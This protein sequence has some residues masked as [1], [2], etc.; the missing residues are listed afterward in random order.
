[1]KDLILGIGESFLNIT[2]FIV[3]IAVVIIGLGAIFN[4]GFFYG[5]SIIVIGIIVITV[6]TYFIYLLIDI[7]DKSAK[8][9]ELLSKILEDK[10]KEL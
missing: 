3:T 2:V 7:R 1:M 4:Q 5:V 10:N 6:S 8:T 9:N